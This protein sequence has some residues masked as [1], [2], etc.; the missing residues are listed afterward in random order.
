MTSTDFLSPSR[1][2]TWVQQV[3]RHAAARPDGVAMRYMGATTTWAQLED[4]SRRL[5]TAL[6]ERGVGAG[7]RVVLLTMNC[8][9]FIETMIAVHRLGA[10]AVP[11][12]FRLV[13]QEV[14]FLLEDSGASAVVVEER[15]A[16]LAKSAMAS[17]G[18]LP[19]LVIGDDAA[20]V[21][22]GGALYEEAIAAA[23]PSELEGPSDL[24]TLAFIMYTSGTTGRPKGA[25]L[26]YRNLLSQTLTQIRIFEMTG[27][28]EVS[29]VV[30]PMFHIAAVGLI[31]PCLYIGSTMV[32]TPL[33]AF[34][35]EAFLDMLEQEK[36]TNAFAVP[37]QWQA[38]C[39]SPTVAS[40]D[41]RLRTLAWG[42]APATP[43]VLR[44]MDR[45][46]AGVP[47]V[48]CFGQTEMSPVTCALDGRDAV[49]KMG[50]IG[51]PVPMVEVR[52]VDSDMNDV[53]QGEIG[54]IVYRGPQV[55]QGYWRN[56]EATRDAFRGGWFHSGDL[57]RVDED[58]FYFVVDRIKDMI[59]SGGEN[60]YSAEVEA[61]V[62]D[63]PRVREVAVV[64]APH[65][66]WGETPVAMVVP[67]DADAPPSQEDVI[68]FVGERLA[69]YKKPTQVIVLPELP[70]NASG[71]IL[72][73]SLRSMIEVAP[74]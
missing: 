64:G 27:S 14:A 26:N 50:S 1:P 18:G 3:G 12:N 62:A 70:R 39:A 32:V 66:K 67:V 29:A 71:K 25:M 43:A 74:A 54:E 49:V 24:E 52:V 17:G 61:V 15:L 63:H 2:I 22:D 53:P 45:A 55:M 46:F 68:A 28:D 6:A 41:L 65:P 40:R 37:A 51:K 13:A 21:G 59:I 7:D 56:E 60:I 10:V 36:C 30:S 69:S 23:R 4:R 8:P 38:V 5:A 35:P 47:N 20:A 9:E 33:G 31:V 16:P 48:S 34:D 72:K 58:G 42:A 57:V 19:S 44:A 73:P 11:I